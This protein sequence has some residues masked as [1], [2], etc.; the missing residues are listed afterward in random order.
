MLAF[1]WA[2]RNLLP[3][4]LPSML[5]IEDFDHLVV[6]ASGILYKE[7]N[8]LQIDSGSGLGLNSMVVIAGDVH[9]RLHDVLFLLK[10]IDFPSND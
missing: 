5:P 3:S 10:D 6:T 8:N 2:S 1:D 7:P 4:E 9:G